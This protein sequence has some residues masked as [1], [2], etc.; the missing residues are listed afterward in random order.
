MTRCR[1]SAAQIDDE[2]E[3]RRHEENPLNRW[4]VVQGNRGRQHGWPGRAKTRSTTTA[5]DEL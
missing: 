3:G 5:P 2:D 4:V 1:M